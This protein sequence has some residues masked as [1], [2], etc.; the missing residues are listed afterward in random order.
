V[1]RDRVLPLGR[2]QLVVR[3]IEMEQHPKIYSS[4][5]TYN[6]MPCNGTA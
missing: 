3:V 4:L 1:G 6:G 5:L 2:F